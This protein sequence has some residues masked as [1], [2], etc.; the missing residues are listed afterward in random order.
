MAYALSLDPQHL[1]LMF[2]VL[3]FAAMAQ[4]GAPSPMVH[5]FNDFTFKNDYITP[6]GLLVTNK[7]LTIQAVN[8]LAANMYH[9]A[10]G[11]LDDINFVTGIFND[12]NPGNNNSPAGTNSMHSWG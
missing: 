12:I 4:D 7:G 5:G 10:E 3:P 6:R 2:L 9:S 1:A 11:P 8:G